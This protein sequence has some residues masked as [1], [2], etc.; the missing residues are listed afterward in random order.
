VLSVPADCDPS[1]VSLQIFHH[2]AVV[3]RGI[4]CRESVVSSAPYTI[5]SVPQTPL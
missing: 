1:F 4:V 5:R 3:L 2:A